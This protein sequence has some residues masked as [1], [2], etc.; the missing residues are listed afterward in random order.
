MDQRWRRARSAGPLTRVV[1]PGDEMTIDV[2]DQLAALV[3]HERQALLSSWRHQVR[4]LPSARQLDVP[5]LNDHIPG[6]LDE[7]AAALQ[8][9]SDQTIPQALSESSATTHG[10]QRL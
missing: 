5:T 2:L 9:K 1:L 10:L 4:Q 8:S 3:Q 6:L 7:L